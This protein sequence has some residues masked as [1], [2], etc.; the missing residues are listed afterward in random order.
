MIQHMQARLRMLCRALPA[1]C[2]IHSEW[3]PE[4]MSIS[5]QAPSSTSDQKL[6]QHTADQDALTV[7]YTSR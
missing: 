3:L 1:Q 2:A 7:I 4:A 5:D 6:V